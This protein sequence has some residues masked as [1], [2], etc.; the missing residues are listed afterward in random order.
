MN[1]FWDLKKNG[2]TNERMKV[3]LR[4]P[5]ETKKTHG[6]KIF[7]Q[8]KFHTPGQVF[9]GKMITEEFDPQVPWDEKIR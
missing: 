6:V 7:V 4:V 2:R 8:V 5:N 1:G 3:N 9:F